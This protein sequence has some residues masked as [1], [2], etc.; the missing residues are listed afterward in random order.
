MIIVKYCMAI[1]TDLC[2]LLTMKRFV[3]QNMIMKNEFLNFVVWAALYS[4]THIRAH[5]HTHTHTH[6]CVHVQTHAHTHA[7]TH[8]HTHTHTHRG[9]TD[10]AMTGC[11]LPQTLS[12]IIVP[13]KITFL[14]QLIPN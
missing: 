9:N 1:E 13:E 3:N 6:I 12:L 11:N 8:T 2:L 14:L 4:H 5:A 10:A 7:H